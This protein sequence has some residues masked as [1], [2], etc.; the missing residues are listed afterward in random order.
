MQRLNGRAANSDAEKRYNLYEVAKLT[1]VSDRMP[2]LVFFEAVG[3]PDLKEV[4]VMTPSFFGRVERLSRRRRSKHGSNT[5]GFESSTPLQITCRPH[6][7]MRIFELH[8]RTITGVPEQKPRWKR[9][10]DATSGAG[11]GDFGVL[12]EALGQLY[13]QKYFPGGITPADGSACRKSDEDVRN[14]HS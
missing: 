8:D 7:S 12:G 9:A 3:A 11:A 2:W 10:V 5:F 14:Q 4:N 1:D 6:S 13:V